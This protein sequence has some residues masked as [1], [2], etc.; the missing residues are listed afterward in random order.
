MYILYALKLK[1]WLRRNPVSKSFYCA[2]KPYTR[3]LKLKLLRGRN[4][5]FKI[6]QGRI[7]TLTPQRR[8]LSL[9]RNSFDIFFTANSIVSYREFISRA[10][11]TFVLNGLVDSLA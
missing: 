10:L 2:N 6:N 7:T 3:G 4:E 8:Y 5:D 11:S 9:T 1:L